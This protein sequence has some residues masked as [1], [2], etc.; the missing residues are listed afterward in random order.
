M[1]QPCVRPRAMSLSAAKRLMPGPKGFGA[2]LRGARGRVPGAAQAQ[3]RT[4][5]LPPHTP[6][7]PLVEAGDA[8]E[9]TPRAC[10][11]GA[12]ATGRALPGLAT[13]G[14]TWGQSRAPGARADGIEGPPPETHG[15]PASHVQSSGC[16]GTDS[17]QP[18]GTGRTAWP[19]QWALL[20]PHLG[21]EARPHPP[22]RHPLASQEPSCT[23]SP[24]GPHA[25]LRRGSGVS[26]R[27][28]HS[29]AG[30]GA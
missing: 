8:G 16:L 13:M 21:P 1:A 19:L 23:R 9:M 20:A 7:R 27:P 29:S 26:T 24:E 25:P 15:A 22:R 2:R 5:A 11:V 6:A 3:R 17:P 12:L 14:G 28:P 30:P 18:Q 4:R 10:S